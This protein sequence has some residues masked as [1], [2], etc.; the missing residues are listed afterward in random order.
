MD[1]PVRVGLVFP[2]SGQQ[3]S[4]SV[5][6][7]VA[8]NLAVHDNDNRTHSLEVRPVVNA[9]TAHTAQ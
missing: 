6:S 9:S 8:R 7:H 5:P 3:V 1:Q 2:R 4:V